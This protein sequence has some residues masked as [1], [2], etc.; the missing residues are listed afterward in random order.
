MVKLIVRFN[1]SVLS[2][3]QGNQC[4]IRHKIE[5]PSRTLAVRAVS[6]RSPSFVTFSESNAKALLSA[7]PTKMQ[8]ASRFCALPGASYPSDSIPSYGRTAVPAFP[9]P[10]SVSHC[11]SL[12][13]VWQ[14]SIFPCRL[15]D[16]GRVTPLLI[17]AE[18]KTTSG[19]CPALPAYP[20]ILFWLF[21]FLLPLALSYILR[22]AHGAP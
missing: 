20:D 8:P 22:T 14:S 4:R 3:F 10:L 21:L 18:G 9:L 2:P 16:R 19:S 15:I 7:T 11:P 1:H 17:I 12:H 6:G 13:S 5:K